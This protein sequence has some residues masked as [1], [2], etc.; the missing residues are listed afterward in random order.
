MLEKG[1]LINNLNWITVLLKKKKDKII[2]FE[3]LMALFLE[4]QGRS[5]VFGK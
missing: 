2:F 5:A 3:G 4:S 1:V